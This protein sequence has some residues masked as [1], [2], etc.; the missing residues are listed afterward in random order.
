MNIDYTQFIHTNFIYK[1]KIKFDAY[2]EKK[3]IKNISKFSKSK[4]I[5]QNIVK[6]E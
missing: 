2:L 6:L 1:N 4:T 5:S 3:K